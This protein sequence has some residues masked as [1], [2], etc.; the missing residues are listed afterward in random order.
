M[1]REFEERRV[2]EHARAVRRHQPA[3]PPGR[4]P[5]WG[6]TIQAPAPAP[7]IPVPSQRA[8]VPGGHEEAH[9]GVA[10]VDEHRAGPVEE[11]GEHV[12]GGVAELARQDQDV[13]GLPAGSSATP[14]GLRSHSH[15][16]ASGS[17]AT[18]ASHST[19]A[20]RPQCR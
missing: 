3:N 6:T 12:E 13:P 15:R 2:G 7:R 9:A 19:A 4:R 11:A 20:L 1:H 18:D 5:G 10:E 14:S 16:Q 17:G 8:A